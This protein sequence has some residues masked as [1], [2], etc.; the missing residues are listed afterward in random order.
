VT[1]TTVRQDDP[2]T[3]GKVRV[4]PEQVRIAQ[5]MNVADPAKAI[6]NFLKRQETGQS[7]FGAVVN[8]IPNGEF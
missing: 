2:Q 6:A 5:R 4:T 1:G 7:Q 8:S 3:P